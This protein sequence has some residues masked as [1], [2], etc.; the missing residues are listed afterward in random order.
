MTQATL[1]NPTLCWSVSHS[2]LTYILFREEVVD[3][4]NKFLQV[5]V[6][7]DCGSLTCS[8]KGKSC[9]RNINKTYKF[10]L[11]FENSL[12]E[13]KTDTVRPSEFVILT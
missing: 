2:E 7:G 8:R 1:A 9:F 12:C 5:D 6:Y 10:Y 4:L 3:N 11:S 13:V